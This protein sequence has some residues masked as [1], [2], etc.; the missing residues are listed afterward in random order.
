MIRRIEQ[1]GAKAIDL[2]E[3]L[4]QAGLFFAH[5]LLRPPCLSKFWGLLTEQLYVV[6]VLS[7]VIILVSA[8]FIGMVIALQGYNTL[9][10]FGATAQL[11]QLVALSVVRE[12]GPVV[13][14]LL[15]AGRAGSALTAEIGLMRATDQL[16]AMEMMAVNPLSRVIFPRLLAGFI[17]LPV[18][19]LVF[20]GVA[21]FGGYVV[22]VAWLGIDGGTFWSM[23]QANVNFVHDVVN[24]L[25]KSVAFG[26]V[27]TWIAVYQ[28][29]F[30]PPTS[31]GISRASTSTVVVSSV[32]VLFLDFVLTAIML[33]GW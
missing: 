21:I 9:Q 16:A 1:L 4:G 28:G 31:E 19:T 8:L 5:S 15:F 32:L 26:L 25:I 10:K 2:T 29:Y 13:T 17:A 30:S 12:L 24:G 3:H 33:G 14:A 27:S 11:G 6:G 20:D 7:F 18:L 23:M 22:G